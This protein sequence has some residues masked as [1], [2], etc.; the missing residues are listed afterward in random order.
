MANLGERCAAEDGPS[1]RATGLS[2]GGI[3]VRLLERSA[4]DVHSRSSPKNT[5][6][7][8]LVTPEEIEGHAGDLPE[9]GSRD[10]AGVQS[11]DDGSWLMDGHLPIHEAER[12]LGRKDLARGDN[13][14]TMAG[15]VLWHLGRMPVAGEK[16]AWRDLSIEVVDMD[17]LVIDKLCSAPTTMTHACE[18]DSAAV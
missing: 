10:V 18:R 12:T 16:L 17:G 3:L 15:F 6:H 1:R 13:Y 2:A 5:R 11:R 9:M 14:N 8:R 4:V 7:R